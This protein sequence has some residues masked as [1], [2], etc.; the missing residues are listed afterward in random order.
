VRTGSDH[1]R[2]QCRVHVAECQGPRPSTGSSDIG[3]GPTTVFHSTGILAEIAYL[4]E[5][6]LEQAVLLAFLSDIKN[7]AFKLDHETDW[8]RVETLV[9]RYADLPLGLADALVIECAERR[10]GQVL[11]LDK[12]FWIVAKE[13]TLKVSP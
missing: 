12:H 7:A 9:G 10:G 6:L 4:L 5:P 8:A 3:C 2:Y 13:G 1:A 11:T